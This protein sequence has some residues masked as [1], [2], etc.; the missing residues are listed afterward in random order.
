MVEQQTQQRTRW[1]QL[2]YASF[3]PGMGDGWGF[4]PSRNVH[5]KDEE[6]VNHF[7][8]GSLKPVQEVSDFLTSEAVSYTHLTLP[9]N[10]EV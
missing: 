6:F 3:G 7:V 5:P 9:T 10:R 8:R 1:S 2:T 4:G